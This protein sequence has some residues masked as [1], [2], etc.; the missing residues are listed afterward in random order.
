MRKLIMRI[1]VV[2]AMSAAI[3]MLGRDGIAW[4]TA[5]TTIIGNVPQAPAGAP[6]SAP[7]GGNPGT[8]Q[9]P[10]QRI[11]LPNPAHILWAGSAV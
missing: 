1:L 6:A 7:R 8:V 3:L 5:Q 11:P 2:V 4:A 9:P 10:P